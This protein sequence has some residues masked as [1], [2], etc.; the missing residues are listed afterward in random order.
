MPA[1][2]EGGCL[3]GTVR[4]RLTAEPLT[5]YA[6]HCTDCQVLSGSAFRLSMPVVRESVQITRGQPERLEYSPAGAQPSASRCRACSTWLWGEPPRFPQV[7]IIRASTLD[8]RSWLNPVAHIWVRSAQPWFRIPEDALVFEG[9]PPD[10]LELV[11]A[12]KSKHP[13]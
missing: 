8:D 4:Y 9:Q 5:L 11:R 1:P 2:Y 7:L 12:W 10:E 3:C 6:C 13:G